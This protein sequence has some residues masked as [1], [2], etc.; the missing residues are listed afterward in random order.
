MGCCYRGGADNDDRTIVYM[1]I[2][3][4]DLVGAATVT[5]VC[6][7]AAS[8]PFC[9]SSAV[10]LVFVA[11]VPLDAIEGA[12]QQ[13]GEGV[14]HDLCI[15]LGAGHGSGA[16]HA[17][18]AAQLGLATLQEIFHCLDALAAVVHDG[19]QGDLV[20]LIRAPLRAFLQGLSA[21]RGHLIYTLVLWRGR[22]QC[23]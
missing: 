20:Q 3:S 19:L 14:A 13:D 23:I 8:L 1:Y 16:A 22:D 6:N 10:K 12:K 15:Q 21:N 5:H 11:K 4:N 18:R 17:P 7:L 9:V 2:T